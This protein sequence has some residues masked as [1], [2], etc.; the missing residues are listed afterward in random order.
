MTHEQLVAA[1]VG[2]RAVQSW[3]RRGRLFRRHRGVYA[4][5][6]TAL[7]PF[8][9][10]MAALLACGPRAL[11]SQGSAAH[12]WGFQPRPQ[13]IDV[14][15]VGRQAR[16]KDGI[17]L[18]RTAWL[19]RADLRHIDRIPLTSPARTLLDLAAYLKD[20]A[21]LE[22]A[23]HEAIA[24]R[25]VTV[26]QIKAVLKRYPRR[27]GCGRLAALLRSNHGATRSGGE[28][29]L[30][31]HLRNSGLP[32]PRINTKIDRWQADFYW[33]DARLVVEVDGSDFH[34]SRRAIERD[35]RKDV[36]FKALGID[37]LRFTG[38]QVNRELELVLVAIG[39]AYAL[40]TLSPR[41][42]SPR[43]RAGS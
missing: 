6:H 10:H 15:T 19:A 24:L 23:L 7:P 14:M 22:R 36:A 29:V 32:A 31:R 30:L 20:D 28:L 27:R 39:R 38:R 3:L 8:S 5:G 12:M 21:E 2:K 9:D 33:P 41:A 26:G 18:R 1:G 13:R 40:G 43:A 37:V 4:L 11:I 17:R 25:L 35:H 42:L 34:S 16:K